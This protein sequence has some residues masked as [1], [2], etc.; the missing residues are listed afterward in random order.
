[1]LPA[2]WPR[3]SGPI[4]GQVQEQGATRLGQ[5][6]FPFPCFLPLFPKGLLLGGRRPSSAWSW[7]FPDDMASVSRSSPPLFLPVIVR[8][9]PDQVP[10]SRSAGVASGEVLRQ[11]S[12]FSSFPFFPPFSYSIDQK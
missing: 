7:R 10:P 12:P 2:R 3:P 1:V 8:V 4:F 11:L 5:R 6:I 9:P